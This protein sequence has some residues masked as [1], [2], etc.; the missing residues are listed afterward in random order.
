M[1]TFPDDRSR[2]QLGGC[3]E[4]DDHGIRSPV[5]RKGDRASFCTSIPAILPT[6][7]RLSHATLLSLHAVLSQLQRKGALPALNH[8]FFTRTGNQVLITAT[9]LRIQLYW[10]LS[11]TDH[12]DVLEAEDLPGTAFSCPGEWFLKLARPLLR[13]PAATLSLRLAHGH[14]S[15]LPSRGPSS[16]SPEDSLPLQEQPAFHTQCYTSSGWLSLGTLRTAL[17]LVPFISDDTTRHVLNG[18]CIERDGTVVA[19]DGR[20]LAQ[21]P[22]PGTAL[23]APLILPATVLKTLVQSLPDTTPDTHHLPVWTRPQPENEPTF[24]PATILTQIGTAWL[25]METVDGTFPNWRQVLPLSKDARLF[26][27]FD[28]AFTAT[29]QHHLRSTRDPVTVRLEAQADR[30]FTASC[31]TRKS[32]LCDPFSAG[33]WKGTQPFTVAYNGDFLLDNLTFSGRQARL[34]DETSP[35]T[36][37][38]PGQRQSVLMPVRL[39]VAVAK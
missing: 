16:R 37:G 9:D 22:T 12:P 27:T 1:L 30:T 19:T 34:N 20:R 21:A 23:P 5:L 17:A 2:R 13:D 15:A 33:T 8:V 32:D 3:T 7:M 14:L 10:P 6:A 18:A 4:G 31:H 29:L 35:L 28:E 38:L 25:R 11:P 26:L 39:D 36:L 24:S